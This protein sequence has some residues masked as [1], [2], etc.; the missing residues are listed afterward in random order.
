MPKS[1]D[2]KLWEKINNLLVDFEI[3]SVIPSLDETLLGW[4]ERKNDF[5]EKNIHVLLSDAEVIKIF[6][7]KWLTYQFFKE[8]HIPTPETSLEQKYPLIKPRLGRGSVGVF[9]TNDEVAME[10]NVSQELIEGTEY[11]I[12]V[13]CNKESKPVYIV[14][15]KRLNVKDGKSTAGIVIKHDKINEYVNEICAATTFVGPINIQCFETK[16]GDI[17]FIE[18]NPRIA[19][20]MALGFAATENW[21]N[22]MVEHFINNQEIHPTEVKYGLK[23]MRYYSEVFTFE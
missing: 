18:I 6:Q 21:V 16:E 5:E 1:N 2:A 23:M 8:N 22:L 7:D 19:G 13:F 11:T 20:G 14:P 9:V 17:K 15:R 3:D 4:A 12:D 10:G